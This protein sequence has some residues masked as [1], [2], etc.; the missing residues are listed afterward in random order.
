MICRCKIL[1]PYY[2]MTSIIDD[3]NDP[4]AYDNLTFGGSC[5]HKSWYLKVMG[6]RGRDEGSKD[7]KN[8]VT[9]LMHSP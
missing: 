7:V 6:A 1:E 3:L 4:Y 9:L 5:F 2:A 8:A